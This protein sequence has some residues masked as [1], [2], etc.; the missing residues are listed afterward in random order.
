MGG[1]GR[2]KTN[3]PVGLSVSAPDEGPG[4]LEGAP[5]PLVA[6]FPEAVPRDQ[7]GSPAGGVGDGQGNFPQGERSAQVSRGPHRTQGTSV[8]GTLLYSECGG[9]KRPVNVFSIEAG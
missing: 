3:D 5:E 1:P 8:A 4:T 2:D 6:I 7:H 9:R